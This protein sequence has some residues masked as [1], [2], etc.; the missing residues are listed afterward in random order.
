MKKYI[1]LFLIYWLIAIAIITIGLVIS[2]SFICGIFCGIIYSF[3]TDL[4][5]L[6][7]KEREEK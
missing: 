2:K 1:K 5:G 7:F 6:H 3:I 4:I